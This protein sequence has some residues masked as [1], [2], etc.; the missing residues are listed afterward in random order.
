[1]G[2]IPPGEE[3]RSLFSP[4]TCSDRSS[5]AGT[6]W[7]FPGDGRVAR[8]EYHLFRRKKIHLFL[9]G[10]RKEEKERGGEYLELTVVFYLSEEEKVFSGGES[11]AGNR[12]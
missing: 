3:K 1:M 2:K 10:K 7:P 12:G 9:M 5:A 6:L 8:K 4:Q 11:W